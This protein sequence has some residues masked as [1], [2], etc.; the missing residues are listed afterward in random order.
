M[1]GERIPAMESPTTPVF[2]LVA[3]GADETNTESMLLNLDQVRL[4]DQITRDTARLVFSEEFTV[5]IHG[6]AVG[7]MMALLASNS[8]T[9]DGR[10]LIEALGFDQ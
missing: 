9:P 10:P 5:T 4:V 1:G 3:T 8:I 7:E 2:M 6:K